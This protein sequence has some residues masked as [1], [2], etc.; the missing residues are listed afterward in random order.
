LKAGVAAEPAAEANGKTPS[1]DAVDPAINA[2]SE[3]IDSIA[4]SA[5]SSTADVAVAESRVVTPTSEPTP[6]KATKP[7]GRKKTAVVVAPPEPA[8]DLAATATGQNEPSAGDT[9]ISQVDVLMQ[10]TNPDAPAADSAAIEAEKPVMKRGRS[11]KEVAKE[12]EP[13]KVK[14]PK[15][16]VKRGPKKGTKAP[17][18][19][20]QHE[21]AAQGS[22]AE[23]LPANVDGRESAATAA[24]G[25]L[26]RVPG[27]A[28]GQCLQ[29][30]RDKS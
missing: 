27:D 11:A 28:A 13:K 26:E 12:K 6:A 17:T 8:L 4:K 18:T 25:V 19:A 30:C 7:R 5:T 10:D 3:E 20:D 2:T 22:Q 14:E 29:T 9:P 15:T 24:E 16:P 23:V 1:E 21:A